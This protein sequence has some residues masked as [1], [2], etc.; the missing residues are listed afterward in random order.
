MEDTLALTSDNVEIEERDEGKRKH[1]DAWLSSSL[2]DSN[3]PRLE[4]MARENVRMRPIIPYLH[5]SY[6][7]LTKRTKRTPDI[8]HFLHSKFF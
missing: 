2:T 6:I 1:A 3:R 8:L 5:T 4:N 7:F